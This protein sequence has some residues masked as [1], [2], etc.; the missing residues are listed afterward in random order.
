MENS[1][2]EWLGEVPAQREMDA[3]DRYQRLKAAIAEAEAEIERGEEDELT[4]ALVDK[5]RRVGE[6]MVR[7]GIAPDPD[8]CP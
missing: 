5:M 1:G 4:P 3:R 2:L 6:R 7:E 8:V